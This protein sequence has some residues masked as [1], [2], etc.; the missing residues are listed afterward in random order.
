MKKTKNGRRLFSR[1]FKVAAIKRVQKGE[2][3]A[4][5]ARDLRISVRVLARWR[6]Q[7]RHGGESALGQI[8][9]RV[10][11]KSSGDARR[12]AQVAELERLVGRQQ[13]AIDFLE[14]ALRRVEELGRI[15]S[16]NGAGA[17]SK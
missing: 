3:Q 11:K 6:S 5:V 8:G 15:K 14:Q 4:D 10:A 2:R 9:R 1:A 16:G 12:D 13:A 7:I 17:S